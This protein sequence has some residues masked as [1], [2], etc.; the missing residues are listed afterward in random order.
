M[1]LSGLPGEVPQGSSAKTFYPFYDTAL[2]VLGA[3]RLLFGSDHPVSY[4]HWESVEAV[5]GWLEDRGLIN[6]QIPEQIFS[7]NARLAYGL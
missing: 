2:E 6:G 4:G 5:L 7:R 3:Q 1:K